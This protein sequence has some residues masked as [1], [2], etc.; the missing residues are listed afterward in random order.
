MMFILNF[1]RYII[2]AAK[3]LQ[4]SLMASHELSNQIQ[5]KRATRCLND[6]HTNNEEIRIIFKHHVSSL[7]L[8]NSRKHLSNNENDDGNK[9]Q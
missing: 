2:P 6:C 8:I 5:L 9:R 1:I 3:T 4:D 7:L